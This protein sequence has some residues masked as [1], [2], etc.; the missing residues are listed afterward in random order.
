MLVNIHTHY[1][2][3][4][5]I[6]IVNCSEILNFPSYY[7]SGIHP[8]NAETN[9]LKIS[10]LENK[11]QDKFMLAIGEIGLDKIKGPALE[12]QKTCFIDQVLIAEKI[13]RP[14]II[15]CVKAWNEIMEIKK[16]LQP[17]QT[18][19]FHGFTK[20]S[21][22]ESVL[23]EGL[24]ISIGAGIM[25]NLKLQE[26]LKNIPNEQLFLETDDSEITILEIYKKVST[27]KNLSLSELEEIIEN[28]FNRIFRI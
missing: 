2:R 5:S 26:A 20:V 22:L 14:V 15:H 23:Q 12:I 1:K 3:A 8:W 19:I 28:N 24:M 9:S 21:I 16:D 4:D 27:I 7:S 18:W 6:E 11:A 10:N 17:K 25:N 13:N